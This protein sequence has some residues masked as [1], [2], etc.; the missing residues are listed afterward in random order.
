MPKDGHLGR[1]LPQ[2]QVLG[3]RAR[4]VRISALAMGSSRPTSDRCDEAQAR[5]G[6]HP[7]CR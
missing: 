2:E 6:S 3:L 1:L 5:W 4:R 7:S